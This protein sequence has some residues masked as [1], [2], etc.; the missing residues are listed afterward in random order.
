[1]QTRSISAIYDD[2]DYLLRAERSEDRDRP[3][4]DGQFEIEA[5]YAYSFDLAD[6]QSVNCGLSISTEH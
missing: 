1:M 3:I 6:G 4:C 5:R 2:V